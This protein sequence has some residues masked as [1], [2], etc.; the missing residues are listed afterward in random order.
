MMLKF[1]HLI[2][3]YAEWVMHK[4]VRIN[5]IQIPMCMGF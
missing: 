1:R 3:L 5:K 2:G 4:Q